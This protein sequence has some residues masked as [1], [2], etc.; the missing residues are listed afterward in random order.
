MKLKPGIGYYLLE[1]RCCVRLHT[2]LHIVACCWA[3]VVSQTFSPM[4]TDV[5]LLG[6]A[7]SVCT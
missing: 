7:A 6:V 3:G 5:T 1:V 4:Q 2:L